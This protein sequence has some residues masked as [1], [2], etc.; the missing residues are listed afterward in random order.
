VPALLWAFFGFI[1]VATLAVDLGVF[2]RKAHVV[3][4]KEALLWSAPWIALS[5]GFNFLIYLWLGPERALEFLTGY[6]LEKSLSLDNIF[7]FLV[8]F[9]YFAVPSLYQHRV[10]FWGILGALVMRGVLILLGVTLLETFHWLTYILGAFV[11]FTGIR[12]LLRKDK[13]VSPERSL[14]FRLAHRLLPVTG[15]YQE[16]RFFVKRAGSLLATPLLIVLIIIE[17]TDLVF[18][19][20]SIPAILAVTTDPFVVFTSNAFAILGLR[21]LYFALAGIMRLFGYLT[22]GLSVILGFVGVKMLAHDVYELP[23]TITVSVV[24]G[25]LLLSVAA[26]LVRGKKA[27]DATASGV[28]PDG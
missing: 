22:Y 17:T 5:L 4:E 15:D 20:D 13:E 11:I 12:T 8:I 16:G 23:V 3:G 6:L 26:S 1:L 10:L 21:A 14:A 19:M 27:D 25:V 9:S 18:A 28:F 2:H 24:A 7:V